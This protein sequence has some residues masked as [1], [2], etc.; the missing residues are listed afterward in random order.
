MKNY[1][2]H[3]QFSRN[4]PQRNEK[5]EG[6]RERAK[7]VIT[8]TKKSTLGRDQSEEL[9][10]EKVRGA[11][12]GPQGTVESMASRRSEGNRVPVL[13]WHLLSLMFI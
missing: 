3:W 6:K 13:P 12:H 8:T 7:E 1:T 10:G 9:I 2:D 4:Q 11:S 5:P